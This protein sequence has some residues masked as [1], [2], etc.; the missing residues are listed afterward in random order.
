MRVLWVKA[1][2]VLRRHP[3]V[4]AAVVLMSALA[5]LAAAATPMVRAG[6]ESES[7]KRQLRDLTPLAAGLAI[8]TGGPL[9][10]E[11]D[12]RAAASALSDRVRYLG[13]PVATSLLPVQ[14]SGS[15][16]PGLRVVAMTR[17]AAV[18]H[19]KHLRGGDRPGVWIADSTATATRLRPG[20]TLRLTEQ[21]FSG[22]TTVVSMRIAGVYEALEVDRDNPYWANWQHDIRALSADSPPPPAFV[23]MDRA[24]FTRVAEA[25]S[26]FHVED[27]FEFPVD[28]T[29][30][31]FVGAK[32]LNAE[33][34][35]LRGRIERVGTPV[36][37]GLNCEPGFC[38]T[39]SSL[40][41]ALAIAAGDVAAVSPTIALLSWCAIL[42]ALGLGVAAGIFLARR[43]TDEL[44]VLFARGE[45]PVTFG[46]RTAVETLLP[47]IAG[48]A[49]GF[50][51]AV[52]ALRGLAPN[53]TIDSGTVTTGALRAA[54]VCAAAIACVAAGAV[55]GFPRRGAAATARRGIR[56]PWEA[57]PLVV[58]AALLALV[59]TG[60]G[61]VRVAGST[62]PRLAVFVLPVALVAGAA[63]LVVR[64][65]RKS[66]RGRASRAASVFLALRRLA[67][68]RGSLVAVIVASATA[69]GMYSYASTLSASLE[70]STAEKAFVS[71]GSDVQGYIDPANR[72]YE[73]F[74]F[75]VALVEVDQSNVSFPSGERVDLISG[76]PVALRRTLLWGKGWDDDPRPLLHRIERWD[77]RGPVPLLAT[78]GTPD[79]DA[80]D[81]QGARIAIRI[82]GRA[83]FPGTTA[84]RPAIVMARD[85]LRRV[86]RQLG[87]SEP[88]PLTSGLIWAKGDPA[89]IIPVLDRSN[90][91]PVYLTTKDHIRANASVG[92]AARS[93]RYVRLIGAAAAVL[94][95]V[96]LLLYLQAR[97]RSLLIA[98]S[99]TRRMGLGAIDDAAAVVIEAC[100]IVLLASLAG[101]L[102]AVTAARPIATRLDA[103]PQYAPAPV[104][105]A[106]WLQLLVGILVATA[107]AATFG[108]V[109]TAIARR[110][111]VSEALRVA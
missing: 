67:T 33:L 62:H 60:H 109:A 87:F 43:R 73:R 72:V 17:T 18:T 94:A 45:A 76:D 36:Q 35:V 69:F 34:N 89:R 16:Q 106:P 64:A 59:V 55:A 78:P 70:R 71:N 80:L 54:L 108:A 82:V 95:L 26:P 21:T 79:A 92:A 31:T 100:A 107:A 81:D 58:A 11:D 9:S 39:S 61:M 63:G 101:T 37:R 83:P 52:L 20:D 3:P 48:S 96:A 46:A 29:R 98:S 51:V 84:G 110:S 111:D 44:H 74:P 14:I 85:V 13:A 68:A 102:L 97:Q 99:L 27:R 77:G 2:L 93:Y 32:R 88:G 19:V 91:A 105:V 86:A 104:Y 8:R 50:A 30:I 23:L 12:R 49:I 56:V 38:R 75:P 66:L 42:I 7:L 28:P 65:F 6:V 47:A 4:L 10:R 40:S 103:L 57:A 1:P 25:I 90:I 24:T 5:A 15:D 53:G 22:P 41:A